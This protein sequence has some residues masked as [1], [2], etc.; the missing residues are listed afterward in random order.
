MVD[1]A[2]NKGLA[3]EADDLVECR[4]RLEET[5][6][7]HRTIETALKVALSRFEAIFEN[8]PMVAIQGFDPDGTIRHWN[9]ACTEL[10]GYSRSEALGRKMQDLLFTGEEAGKFEEIVSR[11]METGAA[12]TEQE[13]RLKARDGSFKWV[14]SSMFPIV[15][16]GRVVEIFCTDVDVTPLRQTLEELRNARDRLEKR[17][18]ERSSELR[19]TNQS[20]VGEIARR[21]QSE[22][23]LK[24][25]Q[26]F[27]STLIGNLPGMVYRCLNDRDWTMEFV[28]EGCLELTGYRPD[29]LLGNHRISYNDL[30]VPEDRL[31][32]WQEVQ[33]GLQE[34]RVFRMTYRITTA[35]GTEKWVYEQGRGISRS[36]TTYA[37]ME[38]FI[39]DI[40]ERK[41]A[42]IA[43]QEAKAQAELYLDLICHDINNMNQAGVGYLEFAME[44]P[45]IS[46][47]TRRLLAC[48]LQA[49]RDSSRLISN[50]SKLQRIRSGEVAIETIDVSAALSEIIP[51][52]SGIPGRNIRVNY[53]PVS[54]CYVVANEL[55]KDV[56]SNI[57][58]NAV[59]HSSGD[60]EIGVSLDTIYLQ[61]RKYCRISIEDNGPGIDDETKARL[62]TRFHRGDTKATGKGLGLYL[63]RTL[64]EAFHGMVW[65]EDRV[66]GDYT[67]GCRFVVILPS[68]NAIK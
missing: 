42:E 8:T 68:G 60:L 55:I 5:E 36:G 27:Q 16:S 66:P 32:V 41:M 28:S 30:I 38:G 47:E 51:L 65:A 14:F 50:V 37:E 6:K 22:E 62:F 59:K 61:G 34:H 20:L 7:R 53:T 12:A 29:D 21:K 11:I 9:S 10:Y 54:G 23:A 48:T 45:E 40:T 26:R 13:W 46:A 18:E 56:F 17:V 57:L 58:G 43:L 24:D 52:F 33:K 63:V 2:S 19:E 25:S 4:T 64:V 39:T 15:E 49:L 35:S 67:R 44:A 31:Y 3:K 1:Q